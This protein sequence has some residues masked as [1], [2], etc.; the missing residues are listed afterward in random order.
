MVRDDARCGHFKQPKTRSRKAVNALA[1]AGE[2]EMIS[3]RGTGAGVLATGAEVTA[4]FLGGMIKFE[5]AATAGELENVALGAELFAGGN[6][7]A[8]KV[9]DATG[10]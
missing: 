6:V 10:T 1:L 2:A 5:V 3:G 4:V 7:S 9:S 8:R